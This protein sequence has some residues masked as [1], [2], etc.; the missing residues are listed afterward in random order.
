MATYTG[1]ADANGDFTVPF[2]LS[3]TSGEKVTVIAE[4]DSA[5]KSIELFAPSEPIPPVD[6][7]FIQFSGNA[8]A[9]PNN[10]GDVKIEIVSIPAYSFNASSN[11]GIF[12]K[13]ATSL[14]VQLATSIGDYAFSGWGGIKTIKFKENLSSLGIGCFQGCSSLESL[15]IPS[16][17][18]Q[19]SDYAFYG[20][21]AL[22]TLNILGSTTI[23]GHHTFYYCRELLKL[24]IPA[25]VTII[26]INAFANAT[27]LLEIDCLP[28]TPPSIQSNSFTSLPS[29]CV[30][31]VPAASLV[32]YQA[33]TNWSAHASKMI[34]V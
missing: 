9:F 3:Y 19:V 14:D 6:A 7:G 11:A 2:S 5:I 1:V 34:G 23:I 25:S 18:T 30:I 15:T 21:V 4:K 10:I 17:V 29:N 13:K 33:A 26:G 31:R 16:S 27:K 8:D 20:C 28:A 12:W 24:T 32:A 22:K